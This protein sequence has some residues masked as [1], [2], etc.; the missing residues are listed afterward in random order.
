MHVRCYDVRIAALKIQFEMQTFTLDTNCVIA[1]AKREPEAV[2]IQALAK[3]HAEHRAD[4]YPSRLVPISELRGSNATSGKSSHLSTT[5][6]KR[7][8]VL[9]EFDLTGS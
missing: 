1:V 9:W 2:A 5:L 6:Y 4:V 3:A 7:L 8:C